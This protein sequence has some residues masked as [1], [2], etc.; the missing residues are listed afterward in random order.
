[1]QHAG[2]MLLPPVQTLVATSIF[3]IAENAN[4]STVGSPMGL[5]PRRIPLSITTQPQV[6]PTDSNRQQ[7][8]LLP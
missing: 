2:G 5:Q 8:P 7:L 4:E 6:A 1:M 3:G